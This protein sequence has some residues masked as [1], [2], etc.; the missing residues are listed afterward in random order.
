MMA[1]AAP[2]FLLVFSA[3]QEE[4]AWC[5]DILDRESLAPLGFCALHGSSARQEQPVQRHL[6]IAAPEALKPAIR[7]AA[8]RWYDRQIQYR[9]RITLDDGS[10]VDTGTPSPEADALWHTA[11]TQDPAFSEGSSPAGRYACLCEKTPGGFAYVVSLRRRFD[12]LRVEAGFAFPMNTAEDWA[13]FRQMGCT[14]T[15]IRLRIAR[16]V[17]TEEEL[18][19]ILAEAKALRDAWFSRSREEVRKEI[20]TRQKAF[21]AHITAQL[22][23]LGFRKKALHWSFTRPDGWHVDFHAQKSAY[24]D[25]FY[26]NL[27]LTDPD[28]QVA[29]CERPLGNMLDWQTL[30]A[31]DFDALL[32][33]VVQRRV[34]PMMH[35]PIDRLTQPKGG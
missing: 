20:D 26:L 25:A 29:A 3:V 21:A 27:V 9:A 16:L 4:N 18:Q 12:G 17:H 22:K 19:A 15:D 10:V 1:H 2:P 32:R 33:A 5:F 23:P 30:P 8:L 13:F 11:L 7:R 34:L 6:T 14:G 35:D 28:N 31:A 24:T